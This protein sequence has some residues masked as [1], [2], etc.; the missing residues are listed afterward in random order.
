MEGWAQPG[1]FRALAGASQ[2]SSEKPVTALR[3]DLRSCYQR[4]LAAFF[5][6]IAFLQPTAPLD[7]ILPPL[8]RMFCKKLKRGGKG[9]KKKETIIITINHKSC[10]CKQMASW[11]PGLCAAE[12]ACGKACSNEATGEARSSQGV[13]SASAIFHTVCFLITSAWGGSSHLLAGGRHSE[14]VMFITPNPPR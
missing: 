1:L 10:Y 13:P 9:K 5:P 4:P 7:S 6:V 2:A 11:V 3:A 12:A 14:S 8:N